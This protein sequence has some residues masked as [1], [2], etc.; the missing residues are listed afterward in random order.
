MKLE[1]KERIG[2]SVKRKYA[3]PKTPYQRLMES[4][5]LPEVN[6]RKL[7]KL[8]VALN[9]ALLKR[10]ID[11]KIDFLLSLYQ[12]KTRRQAV[13]PRKKLSPRPLN[14]VTFYMM[15]KEPVRLPT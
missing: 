12:N 7:R 11:R 8:Y 10:N 14:T 5:Q 3:A 4:R 9:P 1:R 15:D 6:K 2:G 13:N